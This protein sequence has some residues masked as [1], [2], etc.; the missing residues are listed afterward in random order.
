MSTSS[1]NNQPPQA[2]VGNAEAL[3]VSNQTVALTSDPQKHDAVDWENVH[4]LIQ[5]LFDELANRVC[6][7]HPEIRAQSGKTVARSCYL[8]SYRDFDVPSDHGIEAVAAGVYFKRGPG[9]DQVTVYGDIV[10]EDTGDILF[11]TEQ[12]IVPLTASVVLAAAEQT[13]RPVCEQADIII[14]GLQQPASE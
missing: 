11:E 7:D 5:R 14:D 3:E 6:A 4:R 1:L 2:A 13:A 12:R 8:F 9:N 10:R